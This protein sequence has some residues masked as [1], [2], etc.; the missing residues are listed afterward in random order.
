MWV[1]GVL[2]HLSF[3]VDLIINEKGTE[4]GAATVAFLYKTGTDVV[5]KAE[6]PFLFFIRHEESQLPIFYGAVMDPRN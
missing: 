5:L 2:I 1:Q 3:Q 4:G 6:E